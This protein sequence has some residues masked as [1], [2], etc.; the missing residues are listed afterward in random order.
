MSLTKYIF[1]PLLQLITESKTNII[2]LFF[3]HGVK[4]EIEKWKQAERSPPPS[5]DDKRKILKNCKI[6][7]N[8]YAKA[9]L[10]CKSSIRSNSSLEILIVGDQETN[11]VQE[12][13]KEV[14]ALIRLKGWLINIQ[15]IIAG[16]KSKQNYP[17]GCC[18]AGLR[19]SPVAA[20]V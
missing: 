2:A 12:V 1:I 13:E 9:I 15:F 18:T 19:L 7:I 3:Y 4:M 6:S 8:K 14:F 11:Q 17:L 16:F 5:E 10:L 20:G